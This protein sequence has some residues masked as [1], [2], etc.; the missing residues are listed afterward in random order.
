[1]GYGDKLQLSYLHRLQ[2]NLLRVKRD[3]DVVE[4]SMRNRYFLFKI[5]D[6]EY[7]VE[8]FVQQIER[9]QEE[10]AQM[11]EELQQ[12]QLHFEREKHVFEQTVKVTLRKEILIMV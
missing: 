8:H 4:G 6:G 12:Q 1:M 10:S 5:Q 11:Q 2:S 9:L 7:R 3:L